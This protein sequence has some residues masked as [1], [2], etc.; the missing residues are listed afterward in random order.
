MATAHQAKGDPA[1][2]TAVSS[3]HHIIRNS[4]NLLLQLS[5]AK[6]GKKKLQGITIKHWVLQFIGSET[7]TDDVYTLKVDNYPVTPEV[8]LVYQS[9]LLHPRVKQ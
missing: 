9:L 2:A 4:N 6:V 3:C 1:P 7:K 5:L 8:C